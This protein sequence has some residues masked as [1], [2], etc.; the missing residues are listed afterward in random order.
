[1][2]EW[3]KLRAEDGQE[4][5]AWV[6]R[7]EGEPIAGLVVVQEIFGVNAHIRSVA[8]GYA[9]DG[10]L[11]VA[12]ALFDRIEPGVELGYEGEDAQ[13]ARSF[14]PKLDVEKSVLDTKAAMDYAANTT[15]K[16]VAVIGYCYGGTIAWLAATRLGAAAAVGYYGGRIANYANENPGCAVMLHFGKQDAHIPAEEIDKVRSAHPEVEIYMYDAGH[17]FN[18][19]ARSSYNPAAAKEARERSQA[20]L[21]RQLAGREL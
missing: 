16:K 12:P 19:D 10:F 21:K 2:G 1:M 3:V 18:C 8:D 6:A 7:P 20:F 17:G 14:I 9:R 13:R 5:S 4:L 11:A 15:G